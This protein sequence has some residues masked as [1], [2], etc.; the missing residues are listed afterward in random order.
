MDPIN[1]YLSG[2]ISADLPV[3]LPNTS[4]SSSTTRPV[5]VF[6]QGAS[7]D[8]NPRRDILQASA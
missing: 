3:R 1:F 5:A 8:Q 4:K 2:V 6:S 7:G